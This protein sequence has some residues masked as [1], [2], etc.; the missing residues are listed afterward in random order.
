MLWLFLLACV[1][2]GFWRMVKFGLFAVA[3]S[4][5]AVVALLVVFVAA[6]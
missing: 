5:A 1:F 4:L 6:V 3:A 2:F